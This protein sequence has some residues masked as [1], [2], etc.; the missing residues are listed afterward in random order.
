CLKGRRIES[1]TRRGKNI[2]IG[3]SG[4]ITLWVHL[5]MTGRF[6]YVEKTE[7][8]DRHH[9]VIFDFAT[10]STDHNGKHLRFRDTRRF[11]RLRLFHNDELWLQKG[12][13]ELGPEP[14]EI[15][16]DDFVTLFK[17]TTRMIK[18][19]LLDQTFL[20]GLGNIYADES[21]Y[22]ARIHPRRLTSSL[23]RHKLIE[24]HGHIQS[25]LRKAIRMMGTTVY[26]FSGISR[27]TGRFQN[28][29][30]VYGE[31]GQPCP[32]CRVAVV[33]ERIGSRSAHFCPRCQRLG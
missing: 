21:L 23:S 18:P 2:L 32:R 19:A 10:T 14:L 1:V 29:L 4:D 15:R 7:P 5:K 11:G 27:R 16:A 3:L 12:L 26:T 31:E 20:A 24:L 25:V 13:A 17:S 33:R 9:L 30:N 6:Q 22:L 28:C 8:L